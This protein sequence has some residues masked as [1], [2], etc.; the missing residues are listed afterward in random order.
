MKYS[1]SGY[2]GKALP[3]EKRKSFVFKDLRHSGRQDLKPLLPERF[4]EYREPF[5]F[6]AGMFWHIPPTMPR[7]LNDLNP[8]IGSVYSRLRDDESFAEDIIRLREELPTAADIEEFFPIAKKR[9]V[10]DDDPL[11]FIVMK[12]RSNVC[13]FSYHN[14]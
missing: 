2:L 13:S 11:A 7:W 12:S 4:R 10:D 8:I 5:A 9:Y 3:K 14:L 6:S 1:A